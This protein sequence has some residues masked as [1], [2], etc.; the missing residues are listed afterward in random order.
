MTSIPLHRLA[1]AALAALAALVVAASPASATD[2]PAPGFSP[3]DGIQPGA[4]PFSGTA[5]SSAHRSRRVR[6]RLRYG[7]RG[8]CSGV[9]IS[10]AGAGAAGLR[11]V[12]VRSRGHRVGRDAKRP[13]RMKI[14]SRRLRGSKKIQIRLVDSSGKVR[15]ISRRL[16]SCSSARRVS[17]RHSAFESL[18]VA[19]ALN[20]LLSSGFSSAT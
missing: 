10:V 2:D 17:A 20:A 18:P 8:A 16:R 1:L 4:S 13:Y 9:R 12:D 5:P 7:G 15:T 11:R 3:A 6:I 19:L 14:R